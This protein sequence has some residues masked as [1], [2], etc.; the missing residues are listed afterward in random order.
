MTYP[1]L[2][3]KLPELGAAERFI[4]MRG[5]PRFWHAPEIEV[6]LEVAV[7]DGAHLPR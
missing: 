6:V 2:S 1:K 5:I 7:G 3:S 4:G